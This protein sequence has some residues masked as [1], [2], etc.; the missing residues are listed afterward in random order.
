MSLTIT[1]WAISEQQ[2]Y[3]LELTI[4][5]NNKL[6]LNVQFIKRIV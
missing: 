5:Y 1:A 2:I 4:N 6:Y 3:S